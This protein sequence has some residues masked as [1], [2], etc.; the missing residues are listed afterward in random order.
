M[1]YN[2]EMFSI[3]EEYGGR[4][5]AINIADPMF[6][7]GGFDDTLSQLISGSG[8]IALMGTTSEMIWGNYIHP[9]EKEPTEDR[10]DTDGDGLYDWM[11]TGGMKG[12][13]GA[14]FYSD[15]NSADSDGDGMT[16]G[17]E[18][19]TYQ[20]IEKTVVDGEIIIKINGVIVSEHE[21][22]IY[23][24]YI[25][26]AIGINYLFETCS[27]PQIADTD[28][29]EYTDNRDENPLRSAVNPEL[30]TYSE[31]GWN[32]VDDCPTEITKREVREENDAT[33]A[34]HP[35][36]YFDDWALQ[37]TYVAARLIMASVCL[38]C[39]NANDA[40]NHYFDRTGTDHEISVDHLVVYSKSGRDQYVK[41]LSYLKDHVKSV[42]KDGDTLNI[43]SAPFLAHENTM[44]Y[45][46]YDMDWLLTLGAA[47]GAFSAEASR[48]GDT[49]TVTV[50][51]YVADV[52]DF[53]EGDSKSILPGLTNGNMYKLH[54]VGLAKAF[55]IYGENE[56]KLEFS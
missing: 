4:V 12:T 15:P 5:F 28:G 29:D 37:D 34:Q 14:L 48:T 9:P 2:P 46:S 33:W 13:N 44:P 50:T 45:T 52:Y 32:S 22:S 26:Q 39:P 3:T 35:E 24:D 36:L 23:R 42:L 56:I 25:P 16:D 6:T 27:N 47:S 53:E 20:K 43:V 31:T 54:S 30:F 55:Y 17:D 8:G 1:V 21:I 19:G 51:Y 7:N 49:Y 10:T 41:Y 11:E 18:M 40:L 38:A